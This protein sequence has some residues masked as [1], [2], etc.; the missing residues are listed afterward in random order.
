MSEYRIYKPR[1]DQATN[2]FVG[3]AT[4]WESKIK[5]KKTKAGKVF[6]EIQLFVTGT[7]QIGEENGNAT[8][9]WKT[10]KNKNGK[11]VIMKLGDP[12]V[13]EILCL[14]N[15]KKDKLGTPKQSGLF[16]QNEKGNTTLQMEFRKSQK[17]TDFDDS[18]TLRLSAKAKN[19]G[20]ALVVSHT[21]TLAE[22]EILKNLLEGA[23]RRKYAT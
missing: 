13:G 10:E 11:Q 18:F 3:A 16:H 1:K 7:N 14:L 19:E 21:L 5:E 4:K 2:K 6:K 12:D 17:P 20:A 8:F 15:R 23:I 22:A 9:N